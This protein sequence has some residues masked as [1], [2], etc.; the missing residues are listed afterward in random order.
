MKKLLSVLISMV[1]IFT[2][3]VPASGMSGV[4]QS[5]PSSKELIPISEFPTSLTNDETKQVY[6]PIVM[7]P[8]RPVTSLI[9]NVSITVTSSVMPGELLTTE[10]DNLIKVATAISVNPYEELSINAIAY[11][12]KSPIES[13]SIAL[14]GGVGIYRTELA[15]YR[16]AQGGTPTPGPIAE[17]FGQN[18]ISS[19]SIVQS[20]FDTEVSTLIV[21]WVVEAFNHLW[22]LRFARDIVCETEVEGYLA[23]LQ[24]L[25]IEG[26]QLDTVPIV[27]AEDVEL[28]ES[29]EPTSSEYILPYPSWWEG[30]ACDRDDY[31]AA[32][33]L[34]SEMLGTPYNGLIA[35]GPRGTDIKV[36][37]FE[38]DTVGAYEWE[39]VELAKRYVYL[40]YGV[41]PFWSYGGKYFVSEFLKNNPESPLKVI[42]NGTASK[43]PKPGD[44]ISLYSTS[45]YGH[46]AIV[47]ASN[48]NGY[49]YGK[50]EIIEQNG[51]KDGRRDIK[52]SN[53]KVEGA[54]NW[55]HE[56][57]TPPPGMVFVPE[58]KF[59]M[60]CDPNHATYDECV[61]DNELP[62][63]AVYLDDYFIDKYE[64]T[65][66]QYSA[67]VEAGECEPPVFWGSYTRDLYYANPSFAFYPVIYVSWY[68]AQTYCQWIG[69]SLPT[70]AQWEKAAGGPTLR[71]Y[72]WG[73][74]DPNCSL[75][76]YGF[77]S[78]DTTFVG[79]FPLGASPYGAMDMAGNVWEYVQDWYSATYYSI[80]PYEHPTGPLD[81]TQKNVRGGDF[82]YGANALQVAFRNPGDIGGHFPDVGFRCVDTP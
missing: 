51:D 38:T 47:S 21:E 63:H 36:Y 42:K 67:C 2:M 40:K 10:P 52:I 57:P 39:C 1:T 11:N 73:D 34:V 23:N 31:F 48:V 78:S 30:Q 65:N 12:T 81:G 44:V 69:K 19:Y 22:I 43:P 16:I 70:E 55:L 45:T 25:V 72:P 53:W 46:V 3:I 26:E 24:N 54:I 59:Q 17:I 35:C 75:A 76:N 6:L 80:S 56:I 82:Y 15:E 7:A 64:V 28:F 62:L 74:A 41:N 29:V 14:P 20:D 32:S 37:F 18:I 27:E 8:A 5:Y 4:N 66:S 77:C 60:G 58:G 49:G 33:G 68:D 9:D 79:S 50:I 13:L 71:T 61:S